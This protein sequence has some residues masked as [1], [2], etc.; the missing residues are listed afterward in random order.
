MFQLAAKQNIAIQS[1]R[2]HIISGAR[3]R[4]RCVG[5]ELNVARFIAELHPFA[6]HSSLGISR[7]GERINGPAHDL[8]NLSE[9]NHSAQRSIWRTRSVR[10]GTQRVRRRCQPFL[11]TSPLDQSRLPSVKSNDAPETGPGACAEGVRAATSVRPVARELLTPRG[12]PPA[13]QKRLQQ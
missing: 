9:V 6:F 1:Q 11:V 4:V 5:C 2:V 3:H 7:H 13:E 8:L 12:R 10:V